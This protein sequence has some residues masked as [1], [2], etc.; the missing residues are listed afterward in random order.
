MT[1]GNSSTSAPHPDLAGWFSP[2][3]M[4]LYDRFG[5]AEA[6]YLWNTRLS[7]AYLEDIQH[8]EVLLRNRIDRQM[9]RY[10]G[11]DW[12]TDDSHFHFNRPFQTSV[13]KARRR[14]GDGD[15]PP[16]K[17]IAELAL[18]NWRFL[19]APRYEIT[20]WKYLKAGLPD[21][22]IPRRP[23]QD[24]EEAVE[25]IRALRNRCAH[26]EPLVHVDQATETATL[27]AYEEALCN[28]ARW[29][30]P[31]ACHWIMTNSRVPGI[32]QHRPGR[33]S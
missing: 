5:D 11:P 16:G 1:T 12:F 33:A 15:V 8:V 27:D 18:D 26:H 2:A 3:R 17:I 7:K 31:A 21:Y 9:R 30:D 10:R 28:V 4:A 24:F 25:M 20:V 19:L 29:I 32:R 23:R 13:R 22:D 6:V 14:C